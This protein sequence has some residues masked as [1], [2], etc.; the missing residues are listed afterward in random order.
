MIKFLALLV[1]SSSAWS[2]VPTVESL[3]RHGAN[4]D[5]TANGVVL[6]LVVKKIHSTAAEPTGEVSLLKE[7]KAE[8]YYKLYFNRISNEGLKVSQGR[9]NNA[10]FAETALEQKI[11][12]PNFSA[13]TV[14]GSVEQLERGLLFS[15]LNSILFNNGA[16][17]VNYL[18]SLGIPVRLNN[19]LINR[20]KIDYLASYKRYLNLI[21]RDRNARK[22]EPNPLKPED[23]VAKARIDSIMAGSMYI[24]THQ[25]K[26]GREDGEMA[27][28]VEAGNFHA[29]VSYKTRDVLKL[30]YKSQAGDVEF[31]FKDY[32]LANGSHSAP[33]YVLIKTLTGENYQVEIT[34]MKHFVERDDELVRRLNRWEQILKGKNNTDPRPEFLL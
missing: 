9:F 29:V 16:H 7:E 10:S 26:L 28:I 25:V 24:D 34:S 3:F 6:N 23:P 2:Y 12:F 1:L 14:K 27:W 8:D 20:E 31:S 30:S 5:L 32:W 13:Y 33:R 11:Y 21:S 19:D 22:T 18:K 17:M 15:A 4:P